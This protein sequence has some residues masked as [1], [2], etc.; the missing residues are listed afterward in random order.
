M[1]YA[2]A[3][4]AILAA[5]PAMADCW[6]PRNLSEQFSCDQMQQKHEAQLETQREQFQLELDAQ[7]AR[8]MILYSG[9]R[10]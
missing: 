2:F 8:D 4:A 1:K 10:W 7:H 3:L 9:G 5:T 6:L